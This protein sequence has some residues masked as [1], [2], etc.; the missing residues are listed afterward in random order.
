MDAKI[1]LLNGSPRGKKSNTLLA[2][3]ALIEGIQEVTGYGLQTLET[4]T[5]QVSPCRGCFN[6]WDVTPGQCVIRD[7]MQTVYEAA[8]AAEM[9]VVSFPIYFFGMPGPVKTV[10]DRMI[11]MMRAYDGGPILHRVRP[12]MQDK[13]FLFVSTCGFHTTQGIYDPLRAQL[14]AI[15]EEQ[16]PPLVTIPQAEL[17][18][19]PQMKDIVNHRLEQV[20]AFGKQF[21]EGKTDEAL[22]AEIASPLILERAYHRL[23]KMMRP[24]T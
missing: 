24:E 20:K 19:V 14:K 2:A 22:L 8:T 7:D 18:Q 1:L 15:F 23:V 4:N 13:R 3:N 21:A 11:P 9:I 17:M 10:T 12:A 16:V 5:L 6:C